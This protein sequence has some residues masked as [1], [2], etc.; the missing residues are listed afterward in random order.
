MLER[1]ED[2]LAGPDGVVCLV[3]ARN[4]ALTPRQLWRVYAGLAAL[5]VAVAAVWSAMGA[6][7]VIP[8]TVLELAA[9]GLAFLLWGRHATDRELIW[10]GSDV[11]KVEVHE[12][13][14]VTGF[15]FSTQWVQLVVHPRGAGAGLWLR[16]QGQ[17]VRLGRHLDAAGRRALARQLTEALAGRR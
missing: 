14:R 5:S 15:T 10:L 1:R 17:E 4:C 7:V 9:V 11:V 3:A 16:G 13:D 8:F 6:W 2:P 12:A